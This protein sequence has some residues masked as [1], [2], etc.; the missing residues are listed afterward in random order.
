MNLGTGSPA[1]MAGGP[2]GGNF[3]GASK[4]RREATYRDALPTT[5]QYCTSRRARSSC[6]SYNVLGDMAL[7]S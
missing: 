4:S 3:R 6:P 7:Q 5:A 1:V 2:T